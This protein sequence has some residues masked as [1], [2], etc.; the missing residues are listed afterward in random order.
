MV[1]SYAAASDI[2]IVT[3]HFPIPA[4]VVPDQCVRPE[5]RSRSG[6]HGDGGGERGFMSALRSVID[7]ADLRW[8]WLTHTDLDHTVASSSCSPRTRDRGDTTFLAW[9]S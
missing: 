7:P 8:I 6:R 3:S 2:E 4:S 5:A 1:H 9:A